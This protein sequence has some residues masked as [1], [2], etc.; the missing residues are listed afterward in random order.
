MSLF[1]KATH[2]FAYR[3]NPMRRQDDI[4]SRLIAHVPQT[5]PVLQLE[6][7]LPPNENELP[8]DDFEAKVEIFLVTS[9]LWQAGQVTS[10]ILLV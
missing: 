8:P 10:P 3:L 6:L 7:E 4:N 2:G 9:L 5:L 1:K